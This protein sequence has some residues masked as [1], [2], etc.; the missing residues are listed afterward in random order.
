MAGE[1]LTVATAFTAI[2]LFSYLQGPM[3]EP[4]D[5]VFAIAACMQRTE[6]F[7]QFRSGLRR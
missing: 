7:L 2:A 3:V 5:Q 4:P 1:P 6:K